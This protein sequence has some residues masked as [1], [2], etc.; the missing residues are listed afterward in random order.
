MIE[1]AAALVVL[2]IIITSVMVVMNRA[3]DSSID[4]KNR[5]EALKV[6]RE[7]M[8]KILGRS[9]VRESSQYGIS[10]TNPDISWENSIETFYEPV[11][12]EMWIRA[13]CSASYI[14]TKNEEQTVTLTNWLTGLSED[15]I[16]KI[17]RQR[18][19]EMELLEELGRNP[20]GDDAEGLLQ[21][22]E[23]LNQGGDIYG[24]LDV[25][26]ELIYRYPDSSQAIEAEV[27]E[28]KLVKQLEEYESQGYGQGF[29]NI[30]DVGGDMS[31]EGGG[32]ESG[33]GGESGRGG[34]GSGGTGDKSSVSLDDLP[35][36]MPIEELIKWLK[37]N[38]YF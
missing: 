5:G 17:L 30:G 19:M 25:I 6:A 3:M 2:S 35:D 11:T 15:D 9:Y 12:R 37:E 14:D 32:F 23:A 20:F 38:G 27:I 28:G 1:V 16:R 34:D 13:V 36:D 7:N 24:A 21:Y 26:D 33:T 18:Q 8:E 22:A 10:E 29:G 31:G 4:L